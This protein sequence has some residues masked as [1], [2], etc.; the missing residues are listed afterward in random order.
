METKYMPDPVRYPRMTTAELRASCLIEN[1]F[2]PGTIQ[3]VYTDVD[4]AVVG[5]IVPTS[6]KL[7][8]GTV[9]ELASA[10]F[11][12]RREI[13]VLNIG[14]KGS[15]TVDGKAFSLEKRDCLYIGRGSQKIEFASADAK[16]PARFYLVSY[17]AH[18]AYP[19]K[20]ATQKDAEPVNL[21]SQKDANQ[22]TIFKYIHPNGIKS[23]QLVMGFT[24]L[25]EGSVWN[26][27]PPHTH[28]RRTEVYL[29]FDVAP[30]A[31]V[32]H[33]MGTAQETRHLV[34]R[35]GEAVLSPPWSMHCGAGTRNYTF[36][37]AMGGENQEFTDMDQIAANT[38]R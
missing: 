8:L 20:L 23:C 33:I 32:F 27:M 1:L 12:E 3:L 38:I 15:I 30:D 28:A 16:S 4:R 14:G 9:K 24:E 34:V 18:T 7:L 11:A 17:P 31:V 19:T 37:W 35:D 2:Q 26:S 13:G 25:K 29:Y 6:Q 36:I 21:G 22:R 5:G 10:Y